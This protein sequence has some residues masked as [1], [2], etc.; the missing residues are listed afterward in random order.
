MSDISDHGGEWRERAM[1]DMVRW[2]VRLN[3]E[4]LMEGRGEFVDQYPDE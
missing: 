4:A 2:S 1:T 3:A